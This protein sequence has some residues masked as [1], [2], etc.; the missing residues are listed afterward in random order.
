MKSLHIN[1]LFALGLICLLSISTIQAQT[2][3]SSYFIESAYNRNNLN[4]AL[5]PNSSYIGVPFLTGIGVDYKT[6]TFNLDNFTQKIDGQRVTFMHTGVS[7]EDF[8]S[9]ISKKNYLST[10]VSYDIFSMGLYKN[11]AFW[12]FN[13]GVKAHVDVNLPKEF[14]RL[15]KEGFSQTQRTSYDLEDINA[16][17]NS[18]IELGVSYSRPFL[19]D[20]LI[21]GAKAKVLGGIANFDLDAERLDIAADS[22]E[23]VARSRVKLNASAPGIKPKY[24]EKERQNG[25]MQEMIDGFDFDN[26]GTPS[27]YGLGFDIGAVYDFKDMFMLPDVLRNF[28]ASLS[29]TDIGFISWS[30]KNS[31][32]M[33]SPDEEIILTPNDYTIHTDGSTS[34]EDIFDDVMDDLEQAVNLQENKKGGRTTSLRTTMNVG[35]EYSFLSNT[36]SAGLLYSNR[37]GNY[38]NTQELTLSGNYRPKKWLAATLSYSFLHSNFNTFGGAVYLTPSKGINFYVASD[39]IISNVSPQWIPTTSNALNVQLGFSIPM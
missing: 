27:G 22:E 6:N 32:Q 36:L 39:Y 20:N 8:M 21:L 16:T 2:P 38:F 35:L 7:T 29:F 25:E 4:P 3:R 33:V 23:W 1:I 34:L 31:A 14:F 30:K 17:G 5:R 10:D 19:N 11:D 24:K 13:L 12:N 15:V 18:F 9:E 28:K 37:F 26:W